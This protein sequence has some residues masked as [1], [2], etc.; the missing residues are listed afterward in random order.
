MKRIARRPVVL[1]TVDSE[2]ANRY[3]LIRNYFPE[4]K[5]P[6]ASLDDQ[7]THPHQGT[8]WPW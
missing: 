6:F 8:I 2:S 4:G 5:G 3:W 7:T 1:L